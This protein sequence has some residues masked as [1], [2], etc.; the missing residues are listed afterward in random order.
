MQATLDRD[1]AGNLIR[2]AV[3]GAVLVG[4]EAPPNDSIHI[5]MPTGAPRKLEPV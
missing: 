1:A 2:K 4:G 3:M 5:E